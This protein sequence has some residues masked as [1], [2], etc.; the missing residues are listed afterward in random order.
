M[1]EED[2]IRTKRCVDRINFCFPESKTVARTQLHKF[3]ELQK[4]EVTS[5]KILGMK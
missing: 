3:T 4:F 5:A 1:L 2:Q